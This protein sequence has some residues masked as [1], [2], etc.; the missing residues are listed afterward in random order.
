MCNRANAGK[1]RRLNPHLF[2]LYLYKENLDTIWCVQLNL[3]CL[4]KAGL[5]T[6]E[7][8][9]ARG[10][11]LYD[12][13]CNVFTFTVFLFFF[14]FF[15]FTREEN[16]PMRIVRYASQVVQ[17]NACGLVGWIIERNYWRTGT[18]FH[19]LSVFSLRA[20]FRCSRFRTGVQTCSQDG[21]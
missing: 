20:E 18:D 3:V 12:V 14:F 8:F 19:L 2:V 6:R 10:A 1:I 11:V 13:I 21:T 15:W 9:A 7:Q 5:L 17:K 4:L 16:R